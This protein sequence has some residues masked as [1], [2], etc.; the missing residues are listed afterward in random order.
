MSY[1]QWY[2]YIKPICASDVQYTHMYICILRSVHIV[3]Y[4]A[5]THNNY[6]LVAVHTHSNFAFIEL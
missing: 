1:N 2:T 4:A 6:V 5:D 3:T